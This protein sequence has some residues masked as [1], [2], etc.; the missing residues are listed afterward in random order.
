M[1]I[2]ISL[3][4]IEN[5]FFITKCSYVDFKMGS[6]VIKCN[7]RAFLQTVSFFLW[8]TNKMLFKLKKGRRLKLTCLSLKK[9]LWKHPF[10]DF[11]KTYI[12]R[13]V[14]FRRKFSLNWAKLRYMG[15]FESFAAPLRK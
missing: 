4:N 15:Y 12:V 10:M 1:L 9:P 13:F 5:S 3:K 8:S 11:I 2:V 14:Q 7:N 6:K